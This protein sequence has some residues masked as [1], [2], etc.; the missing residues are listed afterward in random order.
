MST[1]DEEDESDVEEVEVREVS[2]PVQ[3]KN[4]IKSEPARFI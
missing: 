1:D 2:Q 3:K 4:G